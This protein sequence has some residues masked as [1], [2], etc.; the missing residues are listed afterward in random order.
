MSVIT[1]YSK[2]ET[3]EFWFYLDSKSNRVFHR[4]GNLPACI[5]TNGNIYYC[6]DGLYHRYDGPAVIFGNSISQYWING[7]YLG[8][9]YREYDRI[10]D[11][12]LFKCL[13]YSEQDFENY[14]LNEKRKVK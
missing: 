13:N 2:E 3:G 5:C 10:Y 8:T 4:E 9:K 11:Q 7:K 12:Y 6:Y 14:K 1:K